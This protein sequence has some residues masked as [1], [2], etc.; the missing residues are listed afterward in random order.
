MT[1]HIGASLGIETPQQTGHH[2]SKDQSLKRLLLCQRNAP[3]MLLNI[4]LTVII[5]VCVFAVRGSASI[6]HWPVWGLAW[7]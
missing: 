7:L 3:R 1:A 2:D 6:R 4:K 5:W